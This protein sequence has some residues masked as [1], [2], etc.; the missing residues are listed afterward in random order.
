LGRI[1]TY[2]VAFMFAA[3]QF[4]FAAP[5]K[6]TELTKAETEEIKNR[7]DEILQPERNPFQVYES[8]DKLVAMNHVKAAERLV[9]VTKAA[10]L[11]AKKAIITLL[12]NKRDLG[13][14]ENISSYWAILDQ[15]IGSNDPELVGETVRV[16]TKLESPEVSQQLLAILKNDQSP[17][18]RREAAIATFT[19]FRILSIQTLNALIEALDYVNDEKARD[20]MDA[21]NRR[22]FEK[23]S[24]KEDWRNWREANKL[25]SWDEIQ[26]EIL[27]KREEA[28]RETEE[29]L[30]ATRAT[31][32]QRTI[33]YLKALSSFDQKQ[34]IAK[35]LE[36]L[37]KED[38]EAEIRTWC[39][40]RLSEL[41]VKEAV[42][43]LTA[44]LSARSPAIRL[45]AI[46]ALG[47]IGDVSAL[48]PLMQ[49]FGSELATERAAVASALA[50]LQMAAASSFLAGKLDEEK[51]TGALLS[52]V[53]ALGDLGREEAASSL[54]AL[55][56]T[57]QDGS[58][59]VKETQ[60]VE[61]RRGVISALRKLFSLQ[62]ESA[63]TPELKENAVKT[64]CAL[65]GDKDDSVR[66]QAADSLGELKATSAVDNLCSVLESDANPGVAA[67][68][69][70]ALGEI[71]EPQQKILDSLSS[72]VKDA[73]AEIRK[74]VIFSLRQILGLTGAAPLKPAP[75]LALTT[76]L[77]SENEFAIVKELHTP[78]PDPK[79]LESLQQDE[80]ER[81]YESRAIL[82]RCYL[83]LK[84]FKAAIVEL[85]SVLTNLPVRPASVEY[86]EKLIAAY[87]QDSQFSK[88]I[89][90]WDALL[91][92]GIAA[93][94]S[95]EI[96]QKK[97]DLIEKIYSR[98]LH[99]AQ[100][101]I[102]LSL[103]PDFLPRPPEDVR[104]RLEEMKKEIEEKLSK[105]K[106][107]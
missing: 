90:H 65:L 60:V 106:A 57:S 16:L 21:L 46:K 89:E 48:E 78:G 86:R 40:V 68:A 14:L 75:L 37:Q 49:E 71:G 55:V 61:I 20:I 95:D 104:K 35:C 100:R 9:E 7:G 30:K 47:E 96:W 22:T 3:S 27:V 62:R 42:G 41:K 63:A 103:S 43:P 6:T 24:T 91:K 5:I 92:S 1:L 70:K 88:A 26:Q 105:E 58:L 32:V 73:S 36:F 38:E 67:A 4:A 23:L 74:A 97:K 52:M 25:K 33:E 84:E 2:L 98:D 11:A 69:A 28:R 107:P 45:T 53:T 18:E 82:G 83:E 81:F 99:E 85:E 72:R 10:S 19:S 64:L 12:G 87:E 66:Y 13:V 17:K 101:Q 51:D 39:A 93:K 76:K 29:K 15:G 50:K 8:A 34:Q 77:F 94:Q 44:A 31:L 54:S 79:K 59:S 102:E 80:K 56:V